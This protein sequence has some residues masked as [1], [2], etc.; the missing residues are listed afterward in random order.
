MRSILFGL[1]GGRT[2]HARYFW[3]FKKVENGIFL[4]VLVRRFIRGLFLLAFGNWW[5]GIWLVSSPLESWSETEFV[6]GSNGRKTNFWGIKINWGISCV[7]TI[8][9]GDFLWE[10]KIGFRSL[11]EDVT[12]EIVPREFVGEFVAG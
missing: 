7:R 5:F 1:W 3:R 10:N 8:R 11:S 4:S 12:V 9:K 2:R 6:L